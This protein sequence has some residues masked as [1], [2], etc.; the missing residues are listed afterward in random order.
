MKNAKYN[1]CIFRFPYG[2]NGGIS[3]EVPHIADY[4]SELIPKLKSDPRIE[5]VSLLR[6][7]DTPITMTRNRAVLE[8]RKMGADFML[9]ID[10]DQV[11]D[12][13]LGQLPEIKPFWDTSF[14]FML[15]HYHRG[16]HVIG[17]PYCGPPPFENVYV[18]K[19]CNIESG[20]PSDVVRIEAYTREEAAMMGGIQPCAALPTGFILYD[21]RIFELTEPKRPGDNPWFYYEWKDIYQSEKCSTED[22]TATRDMS[23]HGQ[24]A[25]GYN[26]VFCNWDAWAGHMKPKCVGKPQLITVDQI[27]QKFRDAVLRNHDG[28]DQLRMIGDSHLSQV[29]PASDFDSM[30]LHT[31]DADRDVLKTLVQK[32]QHELHRP[33]IVV[34]VGSFAGRTAID[35]AD[36]GAIVHCVDHWQGNPDDRLGAAPCNAYE[37]FLTNIGSRLNRTIFVHRGDSLS[38]ADEWDAIV[39]MVFIDASHD[40]ESVKADIEAW[41]QFVRPGGFVCGRDYHD[42]LPG[43]KHA[44]DEYGID[45][46]ANYVWFKRIPIEASCNGHLVTEAR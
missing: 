33:P 21:M 18:F 4:V 44:A 7:S 40:Y 42:E 23:W 25:L 6:L 5:K 31:P 28:G 8:A 39:D 11:P 43:V 46:V 17:S 10:S 38:V 9:M 16:P 27:T 3:T 20:A 45:G 13:H 37:R 14:E 22:V 19:W 34:D 12:V 24:I 41:S 30:G 36:A 35:M 15:K 2:G 1:V 26:P 29:P 32:L